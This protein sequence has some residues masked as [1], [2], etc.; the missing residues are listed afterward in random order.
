MSNKKFE[1][2]YYEGVKTT[3]SVNEV[4]YKTPEGFKITLSVNEISYKKED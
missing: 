3:L 1:Y 4:F 2:N